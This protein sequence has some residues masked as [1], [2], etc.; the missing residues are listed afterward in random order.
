MPY[1]PLCDPLYYRAP[2]RNESHATS[3][4]DGSGK[5]LTGLS[6]LSPEP[7][8]ATGD[9]F[10]DTHSSFL[11]NT[12]IFIIDAF[13]ECPNT[14]DQQRILSLLGHAMRGSSYRTLPSR[15]CHFGR[16]MLMSFGP[17]MSRG[18]PM[19]L[20]PPMS[21]MGGGFYSSDG[22]DAKSGWALPWTGRSRHVFCSEWRDF[23]LPAWESV[24][25]KGDI[26]ATAR[27]GKVQGFFSGKEDFMDRLLEALG[28]EKQGMKHKLDPLG[29]PSAYSIE[30][31]EAGIFALKQII[32]ANTQGGTEGDLQTQVN[33]DLEHRDKRVIIKE[34]A[35]HAREASVVASEANIPAREASI[36]TR[37][38]GIAV[39]EKNVTAG[40]RNIAVRE[41]SNAAKERNLLPEQHRN[42]EEMLQLHSDMN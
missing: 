2:Y 39:R 31:I 30:A 34:Q 10:D 21:F 36:A 13:D 16:P 9:T 40:G 33:Q 15:L 23:S 3:A 8:C 6:P 41:K 35:L 12:R 20:L 42:P 17:P 18:R 29:G 28:L 4:S 38:A 14:P 19:S 11:R 37:E 32:E 7:H 24:L 26:M 27:K 25:Q 22:A 1:L 5:K